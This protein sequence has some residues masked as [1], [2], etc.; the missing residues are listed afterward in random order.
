MEKYEIFRP[1]FYLFRQITYN[2]DIQISSYILSLMIVSYF[3]IQQQIY[4]RK[5]SDFKVASGNLA[6]V[7][8]SIL[9]LY[10]FEM[11]NYSFFAFIP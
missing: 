5:L 9:L 7:F 8:I 3:Q 6:D 2:A 10:G 11:D 4:G 1:L